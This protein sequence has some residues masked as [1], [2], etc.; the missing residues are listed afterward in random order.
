M[1]LGLYAKYKLRLKVNRSLYQTRN[2]IKSS[3]DVFVSTF[4]E[5]KGA[6]EEL[7]DEKRLNENMQGSEIGRFGEVD[8]IGKG[9][10][11]KGMQE[12]DFE[13]SLWD[14]P[15]RLAGNRRFRPYVE[16][17]LEFG[18]F[19]KKPKALA[20]WRWIIEQLTYVSERNRPVREV[21]RALKKLFTTN[22]LRALSIFI[23]GMLFSIIKYALGLFGST[24]VSSPKGYEIGPDSMIAV[25]VL[26]GDIGNKSVFLAECK[27]LSERNVQFVLIHNVGFSAFVYSLFRKPSLPCDLCSKSFHYAVRPNLGIDF[28][29]YKDAMEMVLDQKAKPAKILLTNDSQTFL[30]EGALSDLYDRLNSLDCDFAGAVE[31][32]HIPTQDNFH[33]GAFLVLCKDKVIGSKFFR[34]YWRELGYY[35]RKSEVIYLGEKELSKSIRNAGLSYR[36]LFN[37]EKLKLDEA[38]ADEVFE[39]VKSLLMIPRSTPWFELNW[40]IR[41]LIMDNPRLVHEHSKIIRR[42]LKKFLNLTVTTR[43]AT[44]VH[45]KLHGMPFIKN[46]LLRIEPKF[47]EIAQQEYRNYLQSRPVQSTVSLAEASQGRS[48]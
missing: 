19:D 40:S 1:I 42:W 24:V 20:G 48:P 2:A 21:L 17:T 13:N 39:I 11:A 18:N 34:D 23:Y 30:Y 14:D 9:R 32:T 31:N 16:Q 43:E 46:D 26:H 41:K 7:A 25:A 5:L 33:L 22:Y 36:S 12:S 29:A 10:T 15:S 6:S 47:I 4:E 3:S 38:K 37:R 35:S 27:R 8:G 45:T 44:F 28:G